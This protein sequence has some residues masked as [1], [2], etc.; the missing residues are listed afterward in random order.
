MT[1]SG[2]PSSR[3]R[4]YLRR[5]QSGTNI[6]VERERCVARWLEHGPVGRR[7]RGTA[8]EACSDATLAETIRDVN[9]RLVLISLDSILPSSRTIKSFPHQC[10]ARDLPCASARRTPRACDSHRPGRLHVPDCL[11]LSASYDVLWASMA[12]K[13]SAS[14]VRCSSALQG[15]CTS[16]TLAYAYVCLLPLV[17]GSA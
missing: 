11:P 17:Q 6:E 8:R 9:S 15:K 1:V 10:C 12:T 16:I 7:R 5:C 2:A 3:S 13:A 14:V 4:R